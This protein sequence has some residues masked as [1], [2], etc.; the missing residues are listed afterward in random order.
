[1]LQIDTSFPMGDIT[2]K[3]LSR[4][5]YSIEHDN[6]R[7]ANICKRYR[8]IGL[9]LTLSAVK[10]SAAKKYCAFHYSVQDHLSSWSL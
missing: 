5:H 3:C 1:M 4:L 10:K 7:I 2:L 8:F 6:L 9:A